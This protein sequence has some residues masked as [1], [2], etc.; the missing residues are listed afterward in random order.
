MSLSAV[1]DSV[2]LAEVR[3]FLAERPGVDGLHDLHVWP[4]STTETAMTCHLVISRGHPGDAFLME[5]AHE[6]EHRFG[7][8]HSTIQIEVNRDTACKLSPD[9][10]V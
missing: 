6:L 3:R 9:E 1:P 2:N 5:T 8:G 4:V 10:V 7:I